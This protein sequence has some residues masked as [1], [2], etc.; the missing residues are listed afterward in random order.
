[1]SAVRGRVHGG[2]VEFDGELPE[3]AEVVVMA[4]SHDEPF[5]LVEREVAELEARMAAANG[6]DVVPAPQLIQKLRSTR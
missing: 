5:D 2:R 3:G 1:M 6:G 4:T